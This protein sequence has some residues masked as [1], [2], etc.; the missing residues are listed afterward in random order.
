[1]PPLLPRILLLVGALA[2]YALG[3]VTSDDS[4][5]FAEDLGPT[6]L[7]VA[8]AAAALVGLSWWPRRTAWPLAVAVVLEVGG[9]IAFAIEA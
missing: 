3:A 6:L 2:V 1:M 9:A 8:V 5:V 7:V 4:T